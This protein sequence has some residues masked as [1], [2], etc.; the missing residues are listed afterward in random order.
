M[1]NENASILIFIYQTFQRQTWFPFQSFKKSQYLL[2]PQQT[3]RSYNV[4]NFSEE[5]SEFEGSKLCLENFL[6]KRFLTEK[7]GRVTVKH[8]T[9]LDLEQAYDNIPSSASSELPRT[10]KR[11]KVQNKSIIVVFRLDR[12]S[13]F[14]LISRV[15]LLIFKIV[16]CVFLVKVI[17]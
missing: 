3:F 7:T 12:M 13:R 1:Y 17:I 4:G 10:I 11:L 9:F 6:Y 8:M 16:G 5:H 15:S 14:R 2:P